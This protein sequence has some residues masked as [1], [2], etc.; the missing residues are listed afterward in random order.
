MKKNGKW[1]AAFFVLILILI[2]LYVVSLILPF[3]WGVMTSLKDRSDYVLNPYG[4]PKRWMFSNYTFVFSKFFIPGT[5]NAPKDVYFERLLLNTIIYTL[6]V[7]FFGTFTKMIAAYATAKFDYKFSGFVYGLVLFLMVLP[8][9]G[10]LPAELAMARSLK[11]YDTFIG[12]FIMK[13]HFL[14][15]YFLVFHATFKSMPKDFSEA[16]YID[17]A[18]NLRVL[19]TIVFPMTSTVFFTIMLINFIA[20]WNDYQTPMLYIPSNPTLA[21][22]MFFFEKSTDNELSSVPMK[23]AGCMTLLVPILVIFLVFHNRLIGNISLGG[24]KE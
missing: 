12:M 2:I 17:G 20:A 4:L 10:S 22:A 13:A 21:Y 8:I 16:A 3:L 9:V 15:V 5:A 18:S 19:T 14:G 11:I 1:A 24:L 23:L 7:S 6:G